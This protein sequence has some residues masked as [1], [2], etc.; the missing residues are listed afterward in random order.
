MIDLPG[1]K[2]V[3]MGPMAGFLIALGILV[4][5]M[6]AL[7]G[8]L[9]DKGGATTFLAGVIGGAV[10]LAFAKIIAILRQIEGNT[11]T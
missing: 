10:L 1:D 4:I 7:G 11:R 6:G 8:L 3:D 5:S 2:K 9:Q